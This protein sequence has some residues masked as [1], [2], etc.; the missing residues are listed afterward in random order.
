MSGT[1]YLVPTPIGNLEDITLR[2]IRTLR[3]ADKI[4]CEDT[5]HTAILCQHLEIDTER[6]SYHEHN[7]E[8]AGKIILQWLEDGLDIA[9]VSDAGMPAIADPGADLVAD[10]IARGIKVVPLPGANAGLTALLASGLSTTGFRF[11]GFAPRTQSK[12]E[13]WLRTVEKERATLI[14]Y[15]AP[16]RLAGMLQALQ[17]VYGDRQ[18]VVARELTKKFET[19]YRGTLSEL[20]VQL[21]AEQRGEFVVLVAG[22][23]TVENTLMPAEWP[24]W[25]EKYMQAGDSYKEACRKVAEKAAVARREVYQFCLNK[26]T[27]G[28]SL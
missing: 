22:N 18:A 14:F 25:V 7:R 21:A 13:A 15:E 17:D 4:A 16:H 28:G 19:F 2:A 27:D 5:R 6:I 24:A 20:A 8:K 3:E 11:M 12:R 9:L 10:A 23:D 1:L 26:T